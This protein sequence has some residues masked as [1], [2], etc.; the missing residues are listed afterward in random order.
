METGFFLKSGNA[1]LIALLFLLTS[2]SISATFA[3]DAA[4]DLKNSLLQG[5]KVYEQNCLSC[6]QADGSGVPRLY[7]PLIKTT[8]IST[9]PPRL[10]KILLNGL[11]EGVEIDGE[12]Y[13]SPMPPFGSVLKDQEIADVLTYIR[14]NFGNKAAAIPAD[15]V[16]SLREN[17]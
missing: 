6:H 17:K 13:S 16:K 1:K 14:N 12:F 4:V 8:Y 5:K 3:Q 7:P 10:I 9:D 15:K 2:F 11:K